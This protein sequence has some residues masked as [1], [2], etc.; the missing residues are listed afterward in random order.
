MARPHVSIVVPVYNGELFLSETLESIRR[1]TLA[2]F[3]VICIDD[4]SLDGSLAIL[5]NFKSQDERFKVLHRGQNGG[6]AV[7]CVIDALPYCNGDYYFYCSQDDLLSPDFLERTYERA[8]ESKAEAVIPDIIWYP[9]AVDNRA[10]VFPPGGDYDAVLP[11]RQ[12]FTLGLT[13]KIHGHAL[14]RMDLVKRLGFDDLFIT[15]DRYQFLLFFLHSEKIA[16]SKG[17]FYHRIDNP[18]ALSRRPDV[19]FDQL[20]TCIRVLDLAEANDIDRR[21]VRAYVAMF[22]GYIRSMRELLHTIRNDLASEERERAEELLN[23]AR[24]RLTLLPLRDRLYLYLYW[25]VW[26]MGLRPRLG[27]PWRWAGSIFRHR[28]ARHLHMRAPL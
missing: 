3:E 28:V 19:G 14:L 8:L 15:S 27:H 2:D 23:A 9:S 22:E 6:S 4:A 11:G 20:G 5:E 1:Q 7:R 10:G 17:V 26:A 13:R 21:E 12:A 18:D 25:D 24:T 16:F